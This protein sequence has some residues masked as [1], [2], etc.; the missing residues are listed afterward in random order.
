MGRDERK[1][2]ATICKTGRALFRP[3]EQEGSEQHWTRQLL[4]AKPAPGFFGVA[5][6]IA[7]LETIEGK[8]RPPVER[9]QTEAQRTSIKNWI[10]KIQR[11]GERQSEWCTPG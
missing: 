3:D 9:L 2:W 1:E 11:G 10:G 7:L 5:D 4:R 8:A 6:P